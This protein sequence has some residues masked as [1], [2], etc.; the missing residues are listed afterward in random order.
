MNSPT[1]N[2]TFRE[3]VDPADPQ[4]IYRLTASCDLFYPEE[5]VVARELVEEHLVK[6]TASGYYFLFAQQDDAVVGYTCFGPIPMTSNRFD[7]Y[8]I[9][10]LKN[11]Q[12]TGIGKQLMELTELRVREMNG[13]RI[14]VETS[15]RKIYEPTHRF[16]HAR[17]YRTEAVLKDFYADGDDKVIYSKDITCR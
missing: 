16:Y 15:S 9:A 17:A 4:R 1:P 3:T 13:Q 8:W 14:Y 7:L 6:G 12:G 2:T 10:V 5:I 11:L